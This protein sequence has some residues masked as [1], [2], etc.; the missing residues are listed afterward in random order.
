VDV[1]LHGSLHFV[2]IMLES[3]FGARQEQ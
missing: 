2:C 1:I 3:Y